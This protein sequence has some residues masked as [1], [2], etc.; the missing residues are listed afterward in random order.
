MVCSLCIKIHIIYS[1][2]KVSPD[3]QWVGLIFIII[4]SLKWYHT[5][6]HFFNHSQGSYYVTC[7]AV[8]STYSCSRLSVDDCWPQWRGRSKLY[9]IFYKFQNGECTYISIK[10][11]FWFDRPR[12][13]GWIIQHNDS[14]IL[15]S[16][17]NV[18]SIKI[19]A[20]LHQKRKKKKFNLVSIACLLSERSESS[21]ASIRFNTITR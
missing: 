19:S 20:V 1:V 12:V 17:I 13:F 18:H 5:R 7:T 15:H 4:F 3:N 8:M 14:S 6:K 10:R 16:R 11:W 21:E 9:F 2:I